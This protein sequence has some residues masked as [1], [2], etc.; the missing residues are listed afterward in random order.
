MK[1][2]NPLEYEK[3]ENDSYIIRYSSAAKNES[4]ECELIMEG[5]TFNLY[6]K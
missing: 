1:V 5:N 2:I 3:I 6:Q 4:M